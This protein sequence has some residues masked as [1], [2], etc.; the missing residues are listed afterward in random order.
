MDVVKET[1]GSQW[2]H[3]RTV[4]SSS[5]ATA[6][7][8]SNPSSKVQKGLVVKA[9][10]SNTGI[11]YVGKSDVTAGGTA[12]TDGFPLSAGDPPMFIPIENV[13]GVYALAAVNNESLFWYWV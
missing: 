1:I 2:D 12:A 8:S 13:A 6:L 7:L 5:T 9:S 4:I 3:G 10:P 11:I